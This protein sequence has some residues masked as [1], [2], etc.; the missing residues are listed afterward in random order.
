MIEMASSEKMSAGDRIKRAREIR[1]CWHSDGM[2]DDSRLAEIDALLGTHF[3]EQARGILDMTIRGSYEVFCDLHY[4]DC[5]ERPNCQVCRDID[6]LDEAEFV[7]KYRA[8]IADVAI[9]FWSDIWGRRRYLEDLNC[10]IRHYLDELWRNLSDSDL[11]KKEI[12]EEKAGWRA[13]KA[14]IE[15]ERAVERGEIDGDY[16]DE[17]GEINV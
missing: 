11:A 12:E 10:D 17:G 7:E 8:E 9:E 1:H 2:R 5:D 3:A 6:A 13:Y 16:D 14:Q 15:H 4:D